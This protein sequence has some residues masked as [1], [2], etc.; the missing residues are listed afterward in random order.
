MSAPSPRAVPPTRK[1]FSL[2][3]ILALAASFFGGC[4]SGRAAL[5]SLDGKPLRTEGKILLVN[6]WA[7]WCAPCR[8]E[9]PELN[10]FY[11]EH[12]DKVLVLGINFDQLPAEQVQQQADK[13]AIEFPLLAEAPAGRWGQAMPQVL[14]ST[15]II[16]ASGQW[17]RTLVGPQTAQSLAEAV[18][19]VQN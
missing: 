11:R 10:A 9:I 5:Q 13:F 6:Y 16:D 12:S 14:P 18:A 19:Q 3:L 7:E 8:E 2:V 1:Q 4:E 15:F 17:R